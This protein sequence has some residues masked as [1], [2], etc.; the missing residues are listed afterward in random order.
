M[1]V[2]ASRTIVLRPTPVSRSRLLRNDGR[3]VARLG[4]RVGPERV[5]ARGTKHVEPI[6]VNLAQELGVPVKDVGRYLQCRTGA[7]VGLDQVLATRGGPLGF[8]PRI[9]RASVAGTVREVL[10]DTG[11]LVLIPNAAEDAVSALLPGEVVG[12]VGRRGVTVRAMALRAE[13]LVGAGPIAS[14]ALLPIGQAADHELG[15]ADLG[16]AVRGAILLVGRVD[17]DAVVAASHGKVAGILAGTCAPDEWSKIARSDAAPSV[18]IL[19]GFGDSGLSELAWSGLSRCAGWS[20]V[21]DASREHPE[22][23]WPELLI[24]VEAPADAGSPPPDLM[25]G[26]L[27]RVCRGPLAPRVFEVARVG[28]FP[29]RLGS[30]LDHPWIEIVV[31]GRRERVSQRAVELVAS[32]R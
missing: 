5:V 25:A 11:E 24:P 1:T 7:S 31:E 21:L 6:V 16:P 29:A 13:G 9:A 2:V 12:H 4:E 3:I 32:G 15:A 18:V 8:R 30:G 17:A 19:E 23:G 22:A 14:G 26:A 27:V 10:E 20:A 28:R